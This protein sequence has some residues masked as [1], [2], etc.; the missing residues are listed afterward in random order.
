MKQKHLRA[1]EAPFMTKELYREI[2]KRSRLHNNFLRTKWKEDRLKYNKQ[3]YF[4]KKLLGTTK[5]LYFINL[6][7]RNVVDNRSFLK[8]VN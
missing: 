3:K 6:D 8:L 2:M 7:I 5:K 4:C 1:N